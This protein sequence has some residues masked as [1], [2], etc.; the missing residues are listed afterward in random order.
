MHRGWE[1]R[2]RALERRAPEEKRLSKALLP[3]WL[4]EELAEQGLRYDSGG[5]IEG[6]SLRAITGCGISATPGPVVR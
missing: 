2:L 1:S 3:D 4:M 5:R 6:D